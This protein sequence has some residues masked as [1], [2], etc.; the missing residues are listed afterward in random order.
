MEYFL[1]SSNI[2]EYSIDPEHDDMLVFSNTSPQ[3]SN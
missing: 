1:P 2:I 3:G